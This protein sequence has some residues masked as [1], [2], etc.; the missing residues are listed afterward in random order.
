MAGMSPTLRST[1]R[2]SSH[3]TYLVRVFAEELGVACEFVPVHDLASLD[4]RDYAENPALKLPV[5][6]KGDAV[7]FGADHCPSRLMAVSWLSPGSS[8][9]GPRRDTRLAGLTRRLGVG[10]RDPFGAGASPSVTARH[11]LVVVCKVTVA[12]L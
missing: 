6:I 10:C 9:S 11:G 2:S 4:P 3:F 7:V 1:G 5:L 12:S 8:R